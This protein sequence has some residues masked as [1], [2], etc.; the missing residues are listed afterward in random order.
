M[1]ML[2]EDLKAWSE[3]KGL[4][5]VAVVMDGAAASCIYCHDKLFE[6]ILLVDEIEPCGDRR[7]YIEDDGE[8]VTTEPNNDSNYQVLSLQSFLKE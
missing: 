7:D 8:V 6:G 2:V 5:V 1:S 4:I 3:V